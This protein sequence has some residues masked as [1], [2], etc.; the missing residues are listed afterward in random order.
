[1]QQFIFESTTG[2][3]CKSVDQKSGNGNA[4]DEKNSGWKTGDE[5]S[6]DEMA[7]VMVKC[8]SRDI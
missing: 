1:M 6:R 5:I 8:H 7:G 2:G 4:R 3:I